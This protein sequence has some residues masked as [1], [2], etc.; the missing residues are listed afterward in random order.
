MV[1]DLYIQKGILKEK[2]ALFCFCVWTYLEIIT[3]LR[4]QI[5]GTIASY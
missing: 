3:T 1:F 5:A 4:N 2:K